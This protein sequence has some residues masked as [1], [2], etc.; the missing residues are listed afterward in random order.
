MTFRTICCLR[1]CAVLSAV[2]VSVLAMNAHAEDDRRPVRVRF[3]DGTVDTLQIDKY[4]KRERII[5]FKDGKQKIEREVRDIAELSFAPHEATA[6]SAAADHDTLHMGDGR[7]IPGYFRG[8][9]K[10]KI[11]FLDSAGGAAAAGGRS[12][13]IARAEVSGVSFGAGVLD[14]DRHDYGTEFNILGD[15]LEIALAASFAGDIASSS[16]VLKDSLV[17]SY[18]NDLGQ[19]IAA[20]CQRPDIEY[21]FTVLDSRTVNAFTPGG[22]QVFVYRGLIERMGSEAELAGVIAHEIGHIVGK[23]TAKA[24]TN[25]LITIG[26][27]GAGAELI[28]GDNEK[29]REVIEEA[30][31]AIAFLR[32]AKYSRD[33]E[34]EADFLAVYGLYRLG[35]DPAAL[36]GVFDTF[37]KLGGDPS[38][39]EVF[40]QDHPAPLERIENTQA[41]LPKLNRDGLR[42]DSP[43]FADVKARLAQL[44][45]PLL[46]QSLGRIET[47]VAASAHGAFTVPV[48]PA[49]ATGHTLIA[50]LEAAGGTGNDVR[51]LLF[52]R[53]NYLNWSNGHA[54]QAIFD[55]GRATVTNMRVSLEPGEYMLILDNSFSWM[56]DKTVSGELFIQYRE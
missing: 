4:E 6:D 11:R 15:D 39:L 51:V 23:H 46:T 26:I 35:Y 32:Q 50:R 18:V 22:G 29:R 47:A 28:G 31:G 55:G 3:R 9:S 37:R 20:A 40:F 19:R 16:P 48:T 49:G 24:M 38:D 13:E 45:Y 10:D 34:R 44:E 41:E 17:C 33:D 5:K 2:L 27:L 8:I 21:T 14:V 43:A 30:G 53:D 56:T 42:T 7:R 36:T 12:A 25:R 1:N 54:A 52:D